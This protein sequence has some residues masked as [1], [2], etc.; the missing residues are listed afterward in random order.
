MEGNLKQLI[1]QE[2]KTEAERK[3]IQRNMRKNGKPWYF[4]KMTRDKLLSYL[5]AESISFDILIILYLR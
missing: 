1:K 4:A 2:E 5:L 3:K